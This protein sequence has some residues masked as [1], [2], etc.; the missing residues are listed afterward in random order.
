MKW[1]TI[2][3]GRGKGPR[4]PGSTGGGGGAG[5]G[6]GDGGDGDDDDIGNPR[7]SWGNRNPLEVRFQ[8]PENIYTMIV[9]GM[10]GIIA[11]GALWASF[12]TVGPDEE[13]V[14]LR[15][16]RY[17]DTTQPGAHFKIPM[18]DEVYTLRT[19]TVLTEEFGFRTERPGIQTQYAQSDFPEESL[20]LTGDLNI[21]DVEWSVQYQIADPRAYLFNIRETERETA[22]RTLRDLSESV[23]RQIVG[24]RTIDQVLLEGRGEIQT[25]VAVVLQQ[26]LDGY[27][28]GLKIV[29]VQLRNVTPP[30]AVKSS[31][32]EVNKAQ[33]DLEKLENEARAEYN[34]AV[35]QAEGEAQ[36]TVS[37]A[38]GYAARRVNEAKGDAARFNSVYREYAKAREVT[39]RRLYYEVVGSV[40]EKTPKLFVIDTGSRG[41]TPIINLGGAGGGAPYRIVPE[42][43][44]GPAQAPASGHGGQP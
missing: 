3:G 43:A 36:R 12:Y 18:V 34:R 25:R 41:A 44:M 14:V 40:I 28:A 21:A 27:G 26:T 2:E 15:F 32:D 7:P 37:Q 20:M 13:A 24:D 10:I 33:Q 5:G 31:F 4:G 16:G 19:R 9:T 39:R 29:T 17:V 6:G 35:P 23:M 11:M 22:S 8:P 30:D 38:R 1:E 42:S